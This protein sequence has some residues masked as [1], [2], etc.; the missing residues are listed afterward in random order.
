MTEKYI[1]GRRMPQTAAEIRADANK[2]L[3]A[4]D[5]LAEMRKAYLNKEIT[6]QEYADFHRMAVDG[7]VDGA[8]KALAIALGRRYR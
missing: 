3:K 7:D 1:V 6:Y 8:K 2:Y 5:V 4:K